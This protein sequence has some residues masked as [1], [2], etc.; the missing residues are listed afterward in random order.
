[1]YEGIKNLKD[2]IPG[3]DGICAV[4]YKKYWEFLHPF[5]M[6]VIHLIFQGHPIP[7][8]FKDG[9]LT[10]FYKKK[11]KKGDK[12]YLKNYGPIT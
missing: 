1:M 11:G 4:V 8:H 9:S 2:T 7:Q 10:P 12:S 5:L 3:H 6:P